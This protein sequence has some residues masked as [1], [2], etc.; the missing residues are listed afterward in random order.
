MNGC[1]D[2]AYADWKR[3]SNGRL[4][5]DKF[6]HCRFVWVPPPLPKAFSFGYGGNRDRS[7]YTSGGYI[8]RGD[9]RCDDCPCFKAKP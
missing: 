2:C 7:P 8:E 5:P 4:H 1:D 3:T 9:H 6:G